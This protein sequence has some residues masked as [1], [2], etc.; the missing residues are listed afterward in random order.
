LGPAV[1]GLDPIYWIMGAVGLLTLMLLQGFCSRLRRLHPVTW[2]EL[3][4][5]SVLRS[6][7]RQFRTV[8]RFLNERRFVALADPALTRWA[9]VVIVYK[10]VLIGGVLGGLIWLFW[11]SR[12]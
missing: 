5:P 6:S 3:G 11:P 2:E 8:R 7:D 9:W 4:R 12:H 1:L 10:W